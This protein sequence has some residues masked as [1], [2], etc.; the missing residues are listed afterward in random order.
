LVGT[1][2]CRRRRVAGGCR[3][4]DRPHRV[5][6]YEPVDRSGAWLL[7]GAAEQPGV[8]QPRCGGPGHRDPRAGRV[9]RRRVRGF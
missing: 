4:R 6:G 1:R 3:P 7:R 5:H 9:S 8:P 2:C